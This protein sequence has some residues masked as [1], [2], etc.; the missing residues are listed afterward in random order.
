MQ[1]LSLAAASIDRVAFTVYVN[2][3]FMAIV[4]GL[5]I[6]IIAYI[7]IGGTSADREVFSVK[8]F[9]V[10]VSL[11]A[12]VGV[13]LVGLIVAIILWAA[14][15]SV[16]L[17]DPIEIYWYAIM[18]VTGMIAAIVAAIF[19]A[20]KKGFNY[21][22]II[23][24]A[25]VL[26]PLG[27]VGARLWFVVFPYEG[28]SHNFKD[29]WDVIDIRDGGLGIYGG[30]IFGA[31]GV[32]IVSKWK[33]ISVLKLLDIVA[34]CVLIAQ[35]IGRW[36]NFF[37]QEAY[38]TLVTNP[39]MQWFPLSVY[40]EHCTQC[41]NGVGG[42]H[43]ATFFYEF[44][45]NTVGFVA[46]YWYCYKRNEIDGIGVCAYF[47]WYGIGRA[48][49]ESLRTDSLMLGNTGIRVSLAL[50]LVM[51]VVSLAF[52][53]YLV[54]HYKKTGLQFLQKAAPAEGIS[55]DSEDAGDSVKEGSE[56]DTSDDG[57]NKN[58]GE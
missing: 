56:N 33:K 49:I 2:W 30:I 37:N 45:W 1:R 58:S 36:G 27:I 4:L 34:P 18:I 21:N 35:A 14:N 12:G 22:L 6:G 29:F 16:L 39:S 23:D 7:V 10:K 32:F 51:V 47:L 24:T 41:C 20:K 25:L 53:A 50:S 43:L 40:I 48:W 52:G 17:I 9:K 42:W 28:G 55:D 5:I 38:G 54:W 31:I 13:L 15:V 57:E 11:L 8:K 19:M 44:L 46:I 3:Q 26:I